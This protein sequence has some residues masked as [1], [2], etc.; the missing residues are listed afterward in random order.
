VSQFGVAALTAA[1]TG[2][3]FAALVA[4]VTLVNRRLVDPHDV[5]ERG[6]A[7]VV[8]GGLLSGAL[9]ALLG[10]GTLAAWLSLST[11]AAVLV[12]LLGTVALGLLGTLLFRPLVTRYLRWART[13]AVLRE[14]RDDGFEP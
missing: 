12:S 4:A 14:E 10:A 13:P 9:F 3:L 11:V 5:D 1:V 7:V 6:A 8:Y 2:A